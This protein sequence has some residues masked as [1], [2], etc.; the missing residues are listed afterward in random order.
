M[1]FLIHPDRHEEQ[2]QSDAG[3]I[4][5]ELRA[6]PLNAAIRAA[7]MSLLVL[8]P[9]LAREQARTQPISQPVSP[10]VYPLRRR[11]EDPLSTEGWNSTT[12]SGL[13]QVDSREEFMEI[14][15]IAADVKGG[16]QRIAKRLEG[17]EMNVQC[18]GQEGAYRKRRRPPQ[19]KPRKRGGSGTPRN[20][21]SK[22]DRDPKRED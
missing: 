19:E 15:I 14:E 17:L 16:I 20:N 9:G 1:A 3:S 22:F 18:L 6:L 12:Y 4:V 10:L 5:E 11:E 8:Q 13:P 7:L 2:E 21:R